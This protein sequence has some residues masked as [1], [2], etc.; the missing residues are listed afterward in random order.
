MLGK[1]VAGEGKRPCRVLLVGE[2]PG[3]MEASIGRPFVGAAGEELNRYLLMQAGLRRSDC[4]IT[5]IVRYRTDAENSDPTLEDIARDEHHLWKEIAEVRPEI[6]V[7]VGK[8]ATQYFLGNVEM[9][10]VFGLP[11][12]SDKVPGVT[13]FPVFHPAAGLHQADRF[14]QLIYHS[15]NQ[16]GKF[17][18]GE[19]RHEVDRYPNPVY[20]E[21]TAP[22]SLE[23]ATIG[24]DTEGLTY[25]PWGLSYS[26]A[27]GTGFV[28]K[29]KNAKQFPIKSAEKVILHH[30]LHDI[31]VLRAMGVDIDSCFDRLDD[32]MLMAHLLC[33]EPKRLKAL[34]YRHARI[35]M[36]EYE[37]ITHEA[38]NRI[39][40]DYLQQV[41]SYKCVECNG[42]GELDVP[43]K[44]QPKCKKCADGLVLPTCKDCNGYG[45]VTAQE[46]EFDQEWLIKQ[47]VGIGAL[48]DPPK[49]TK[50]KTCKGKGKVKDESQE[51][52]VCETCSGTGYQSKFKRVKC[53]QCSG[54]GTGWSLP[55]CQLTFNDDFTPR[56]YQPQSIGRILRR[57]CD[58]ESGYRK[59]WRDLRS[60]IGSTTD[61]I[62]QRVG[63]MPETTL[64]DVNYAKA[65]HYSAQ[66]ADGTL[67]VYNK[68]QPRITEMGLEQAYAIDK[69]I[70]PIIDRM[71]TNGILINRDHF[72]DLEH[73]FT[74][75]QQNVQQ[76]LFDT[77]GNYFNPNSQDQVQVQLARLGYEGLDSTDERTLQTISINCENLNTK[78][79]IDLILEH[80]ELGKMLSTYVI[81]IQQQADKHDRVHTTFIIT[82]PATG[83]LASKNPNLQN[84]PSR[85]ERGRLIRQGFIAREGCVLLSCDLD[86]IELRV[87]AHISQD[88]N[89]IDNFLRGL[90]PHTA[91]AAKIF[92]VA[93][94]EVDSMLHRYP[95]KT[96]NF[97]VFYG[98]SAG[99]L[100]SELALNNFFITMEEAKSFIREWFE[101]YPMV[102]TFMG[103]VHAEVRVNGY[104]RSLFGHIRYL[105]NVHSKDNRI[106]EDALRQAVNTPIQG[107]AGELLKIA[108]ANIW[109]RTMP[110]VQRM[111]YFEPLLTVHDE[112][113]FEVEEGLADMAGAMVSFEM[114]NAA[115][116]LVPLAAKA[117]SAKTWAELKG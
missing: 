117:K 1:F 6:I 93:Y 3:K 101:A 13:V 81:P 102:R 12:W 2:G 71:H 7:T 110:D 98:M 5:N 113:I 40:Y 66:D 4:F 55:E 44:K 86:Q 100:Q 61:Y 53:E 74:L 31:P 97:G 42:I 112:L 88:P 54:D 43:Y 16:L 108:K 36:D 37:D 50:C 63:R 28:V 82:G 80:R 103:N 38:E 19:M 77:V 95:A 59:G 105:P 106:R 85:T 99:K 33:V 32:T 23:G 26:T 11:Q 39:S 79:V 78:K 104:V 94:D 68:L 29:A 15:F 69:G 14:S 21:C 62:E 84:I 96:I 89:M 70:I 41:L 17:L 60:R 116:L 83:R 45:K 49:E 20:M 114:A 27:E 47:L 51:Y 64:D 87:G 107:T 67:R 30:A 34:S 48:I 76:E 46:G 57:L 115:K 91:T 92:K 56:L 35:K 72:R 75:E 90:D 8:I 9:E 65:I 22:K 52:P 109:K 18:R 73:K 25:N 10:F 24:L 111:G 58:G